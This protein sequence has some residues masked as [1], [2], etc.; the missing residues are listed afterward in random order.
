MACIKYVDQQTELYEGLQS[1]SV[2]TIFVLK[3]H[4]LYAPQTIKQKMVP[5]K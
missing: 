5:V 1:I 4:G 2:L 3:M